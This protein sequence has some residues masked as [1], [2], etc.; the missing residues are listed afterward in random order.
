MS[1]KEIDE[2]KITSNVYDGVRYLNQEELEAL[3]T[4]PKGYTSSLTRNQAAGL[5]G[6]GWTVDVIIH[7]LSFIP[8]G[9][10]RK[11]R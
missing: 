6:D 5:L 10:T 4:V 9:K 1:A 7:I 2:S 8:N 3:Q 11:N